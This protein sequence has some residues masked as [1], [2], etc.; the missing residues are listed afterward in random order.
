MPIIR[1]IEGDEPPATLGWD[2]IFSTDVLAPGFGQGEWA[3]ADPE[4]EPY[5]RGGLA[6]QQPLMTAVNLQLFLNARRP[7][8]IASPD[9]TDVRY[10]WHGDGFDLDAAAGERPIGS[11]L[12][13]LKR[14]PLNE[15]TAARARSYATSA[16]QTL[17]DQG[18]V[19]TI[20]VESELDKPRGLLALKI[21]LVAP[22]GQIVLA[23]SFPVR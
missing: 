15:E 5:N 18:L 12:Y 6:S 8:E 7:D 16:L 10:G 4:E 2:T 23:N 21:K 22:N 20:D 9:E 3:L 17:I 19:A 13:T 1:I 11:L 14:A